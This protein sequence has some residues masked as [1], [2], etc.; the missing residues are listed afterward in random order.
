L[1]AAPA[2]GAGLED[3][4]CFAGSQFGLQASCEPVKEEHFG[5]EVQL[6]GTSGIAVNYAGAGGVPEGTVYATSFVGGGL[7]IGMFVPEGEGLKL[8]ERWQVTEI[9]GPYETC[10]PVG[11]ELPNGSKPGEHSACLPRANEVAR[12]VDVEID[13][14]NGNVFALN[15]EV[16]GP[17][18]A[19]VAEYTATGSGLIT[20]FADLAPTGQGVPESPEKVHQLESRGG[21][22]VTANGRVYI[23]DQD[24]AF[25]H[26]LMVFDPQGGSYVYVGEVLEGFAGEQNPT[27]PLADAAGNLYVGTGAREQVIEE[28]KAAALV[29]GPY[30]TP[31]SSPV[32]SFSY[33]PGGITSGTVNPSDGEVFFYSYKPIANKKYVQRLGPCEEG[34]GEFAE[35]SEGERVRVELS[36]ERDDLWGMAY[37]PQ[38]TIGGRPKGTLYAAA[39]S[40]EPEVG[41]GQPGQASLGY[42]FA[43]PEENPPVIESESA[44]RVTQSSA[45][46]SAAIDPNA[47][48]VTYVFQ[49]ESI[50]QYNTNPSLERFAGASEVP[51]D[52]GT[53]HPTSGAQSVAVGLSGLTSGMEY[54]YR[55]VA[56]SQCAEAGKK[57]CET[58]GGDGAFR[59]YPSLI[60]SLLD[61]RAWELVSPAQKN[62]GQVLPADPR[63]RT[64]AGGE[65]ECKPGLTY[66]HFPMESSLDGDAVAYEGT[67]FGG[68]ATIENEYG[69]GR[70]PVS[71]WSSLNPTPP[72]LESIGGAG[73]KAVDPSLGAA[74]LEQEAGSPELGGGGLGVFADLFSQRS[75]NPTALRSVLAD[76]AHP[77]SARPETGPGRFEIDYTGASR[78]LSR[79][80]F[81]ANDALTEEVP[82]EAPA[83][84]PVS[85]TEFDLYEWQ[86]AIGQVRLVNVLPGNASAEAGTF[87]AGSADPVSADGSRVYWTSK[88]GRLY[89]REAGQTAPIPGGGPG[90]GAFLVAASEG[91][92]VLLS[93][94]ELYDLETETSTD[95]TEGHGGFQGLAGQ[96]EELDRAYFV[97]TAALT[98]PSEENEN[99]EHAETGKENLYAWSSGSP[100]HFIARLSPLDNNGAGSENLARSW[101]AVPSNRTA[102]ASPDGRYLAFLSQAEVTGYANSGPCETNHAGGFAEAPCPEAFIY[103]SATRRLACASCN[104][105]LTAPLGWSVLRRNFGPSYLPQARYLT[106]EARLYFDSRDSL[107]PR[108]TNEGAEDVYEWEPDGI[109]GCASQFA[110]GGCVGLLSSGREDLDSN[111]VT[112]NAGTAGVR[113]GADVFFT[114]REQLLPRDADELVDLYDAREGGGFAF[115]AEGPPGPCQGE[116]CQT[117]PPAAVESLPPSASFNGPGNYKPPKACKKGKVKRKGKCVKTQT[118]RKKAQKGTKKKARI[119]HSVQGNAK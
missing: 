14:T 20:R 71:G 38:R 75:D 87:P 40:N 104:P 68:G 109:G 74:L 82:G 11:A 114:T 21:L 60:P 88:G 37:D 72:R 111:L 22:A 58:Q 116:G 12:H 79:V 100:A 17:G 39:P 78:D 24:S 6:A 56:R 15:G 106:N 54:R 31:A 48:T 83:S 42:V 46:L 35:S 66:N 89:V 110:E 97:D 92:R 61:G 43:A 7:W 91:Q 3:I 55:A 1:A 50:A 59:T 102:E 49:Y 18:R 99:H 47:N 2:E 107:S 84:P 70:D 34:T 76:A 119:A 81:A 113:G 9:E 36:P 27:G 69:A 19:M 45:R 41:P 4:G 77:P 112:I 96:S 23:F 86:P 26:R 16:G 10:G 44:S 115:E 28:F 90:E 65:P 105:T 64:C 101:E 67:N 13:Q 8:A 94:G 62:G 53:L 98:L 51:L 117:L 63:V 93:D 30:P 80:F 73:Y 52:G 108:D 57:S 103:D 33:A 32:C 29:P 85:A 118:H 5:E 95:L 25:R